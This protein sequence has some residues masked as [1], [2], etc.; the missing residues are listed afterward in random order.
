MTEPDHP[1]PWPRTWP[2]FWR[3][4]LHVAIAAGVANVLAAMQ[5]V[6]SAW[7]FRSYN[8]PRY[9]LLGGKTLC[10]ALRFGAAG[11][12]SLLPMFLAAF[13]GR[14]RARTHTTLL[15]AFLLGISAACLTKYAF[16]PYRLIMPRGLLPQRVAIELASAIMG[17]GIFGWVFARLS[18]QVS[19]RR[20]LTGSVVGAALLFTAS[21]WQEAAGGLCPFLRSMFESRVQNYGWYMFLFAY[22]VTAYALHPLTFAIAAK[23]LIRAAEGDDEGS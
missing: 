7:V 16:D 15:A 13:F 17:F 19:M 2:P 9:Q 11:S 23:L 3:D 20:L 14:A 5:Q 6:A 21:I 4:A 18:G 8:V 10:S 22:H 1:T 12:L